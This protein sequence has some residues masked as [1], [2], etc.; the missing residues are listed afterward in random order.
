[1]PKYTKE[2]LVC[3]SQG[4]C[5]I[6]TRLLLPQVEKE[7]ETTEAWGQVS[8]QKIIRIRTWLECPIHGEL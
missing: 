6:C 1:M 5:P 4:R 8:T 2:Q 3:M 7:S